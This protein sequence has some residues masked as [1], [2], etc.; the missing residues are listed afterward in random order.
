MTYST[1]A[2]HLAEFRRKTGDMALGP[3]T[4]PVQQCACCRKP[5]STV[6]GRRFQELHGPVTRYNPKRFVCAQCIEQCSAKLGIDARD[7]GK[8]IFKW[9]EGK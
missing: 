1:N 3:G 9:M 6:S 8:E 7:V 5:K 4:T 2:N